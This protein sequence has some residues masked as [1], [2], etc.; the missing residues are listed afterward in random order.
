MAVAFQEYEVQ[1][2]SVLDSCAALVMFIFFG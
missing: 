1:K 2:V